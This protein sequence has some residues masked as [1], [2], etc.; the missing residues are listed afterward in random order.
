MSNMNDI[1][2]DFNSKEVVK[3]VQKALNKGTNKVANKIKRDA[4]NTVE[5]DDHTYNLRKSITKRKSK[6]KNGGYI[7]YADA[8]HAH[9]IEYGHLLVKGGSI[10]PYKA[11]NRANTG[12]GV[13]V[14]IV[15]PIPF[16]R[17]AVADN[18]SQGE[19]II[20]NEIKKALM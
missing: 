10:S 2:I 19:Q 15:A 16:L 3:N 18:K 6:F 20:S 12:K 1:T 13:V 4:L 9:L 8:P 14:G 5:F 11:K 7:V 17:D